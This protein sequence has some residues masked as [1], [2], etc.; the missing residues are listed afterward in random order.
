M[1]VVDLIGRVDHSLSGIRYVS[2]FKYY[3]NAI[4]DGIDPLSF[5]GMTLAACVLAALGAWLFDRRDLAV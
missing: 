3:G 1:Y 5:A 2:I 4:L